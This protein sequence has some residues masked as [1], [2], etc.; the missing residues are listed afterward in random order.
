MAEPPVARLDLWNQT[1]GT[2]SILEMRIRRRKACPG[3]EM[4]KRLV[5]HV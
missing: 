4:K 3:Q 2:R 1:A 5:P